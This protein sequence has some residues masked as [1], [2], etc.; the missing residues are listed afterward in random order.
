MKMHEIALATLLMAFAGPAIAE[1][2]SP[3]AAPEKAPETSSRVAPNDGTTARAN[4][5]DRARGGLAGLLT[6][7]LARK[8][9]YRY[10][11]AESTRT[12]TFEGQE[13][14]G[15]L[16]AELIAEPAEG[17]TAVKA[18]DGEERG[19][20]LG[21]MGLVA[22]PTAEEAEQTTTNRRRNPT[23]VVDEAG[24]AFEVR[25]VFWTPINAAEIPAEGNALL[26]STWLRKTENG[27][28]PFELPGRTNPAAAAATEQARQPA[29]TAEER[30]AQ[31]EERRAQWE[32]MS[33][34]DRAEMR[35]R[36]RERMGEEGMRGRG[37]QGDAPRRRQGGEGRR[38]AQ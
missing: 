24:K 13:G 7:G 5:Q 33:E 29:A 32:N 25:P 34:E 11:G 31:W 38:P 16:L 1:D 12:L 23:L 37:Q 14:G 4:A 10:E 35:E 15:I 30:R 18:V 21:A 22:Q 9:V 27:W 26:S 8:M 6:E 2:N 17:E 20:L 19:W 28:E 36:M 3:G